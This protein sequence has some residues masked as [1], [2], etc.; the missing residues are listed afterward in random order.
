MTWRP[1]CVGEAQ[2]WLLRSSAPSV[3]LGPLLVEVA[4]EADFEFVTKNLPGSW[5]EI[6]DERENLYNFLTA[7][8]RLRLG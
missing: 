4:A 8:G 2:V 6:E 3:E 7:M 1:I 5:K